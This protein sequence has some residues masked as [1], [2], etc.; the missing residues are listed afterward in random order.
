MMGDIDTNQKIAGF[1]VLCQ[2]IILWVN[3]FLYGHY[4]GN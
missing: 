3:Q 1:G 4:K 2:M